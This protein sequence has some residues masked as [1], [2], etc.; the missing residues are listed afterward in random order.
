MG[1]EGEKEKVTLYCQINH[2]ALVRSL[3]RASS[4]YQIISYSYFIL[5][6]EDAHDFPLYLIF[7]D[8]HN[9]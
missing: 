1:K 6:I 5:S 7:Y 3:D 2:G 9:L 4:S 8:Y